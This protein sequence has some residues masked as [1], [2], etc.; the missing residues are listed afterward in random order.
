MF[1]ILL[2][3]RSQRY[4]CVAE[5]PQMRREKSPPHVPA[6]HKCITY[7]SS[8]NNADAPPPVTATSAVAHAL[9]SALPLMPIGN[10]E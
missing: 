5:R 1:R 8:A 2:H 10:H 3:V 7:E 4:T 6:Q 9:T